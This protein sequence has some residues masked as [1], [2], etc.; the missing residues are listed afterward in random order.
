MLFDELR[1]LPD[2]LRV[3]RVRQADAFQRLKAAVLAAHAAALQIAVPGVDALDLFAVKCKGVELRQ[4]CTSFRARAT[5]CAGP[6]RLRRGFQRPG[7]EIRPR[8]RYRE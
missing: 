2:G 1:K 3:Q 5:A 8:R 4:A 7:A 6:L